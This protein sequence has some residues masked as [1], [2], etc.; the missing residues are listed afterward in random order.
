MTN[1]ESYQQ[2]F[3]SFQKELNSFIFRLVANREDTEDIAQETYIKAFKNIQT[4]QGNASFKTWTFTI[5]ANLAKDKLKAKGSWGEHWLDLSRDAHMEDP[6]LMQKKFEIARTSAHGAFE[7]REHINFCFGCI[8]KTLLLT[9][10]ICLLLK[11][12]YDFKISEIM[13]ITGLNEGKV[14]HAIADARKDMN[15]I[16]EK[17]CALINKEGICHQ[18]TGLNSKFNPEQDAQIEANKIKM[19]KEAGNENYE[20]LLNLRLQL[21]KSINPLE[22]AGTDLHSYL[23]ENVPAWAEQQTAKASEKKFQHQC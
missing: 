13:L 19:V 8:N 10:Q 15:R 18:C 5:A 22:A 9:N 6:G 14:K 7:I 17:R 2:Q 3:I 4:F 12:V 16:F 11:E 1:L 23:I 20:Q 21:V